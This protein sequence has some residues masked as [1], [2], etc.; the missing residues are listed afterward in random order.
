[1]A[2][3]RKLKSG[4]WQARITHAGRQKSVGSYATKGEAK[5]AAIEAEAK[6]HGGAYLAPAKVTLERFI[7]QWLVHVET[8]RKPTTLAFYQEKA[9]YVLPRLGRMRIDRID[10]VTLDGLYADL[11]ASGGRGGRP[12]SPRTVMHVHRVLRTAFAY[13]V[14]KGML[15][16]N[17]CETADAPRV[18]QGTP[19]VW[20]VPEVQ[21]FLMA[22]HNHRLEAA[23]VLA[24][25][26][27]M[28]R[29]EIAGLTWDAVNLD[30]GEVYVRSTRVM[31][32]GI[33]T[34]S[35]PKTEGSARM[36]A[37]NRSTVQVLREHRTRQRQER[38][39]SLDWADTGYVFTREDGRPV[40]PQYLYTLMQRTAH[41]AGLPPISFHGLRH[42]FAT[43]ALQAKQ[44][45]RLVAELLGHE[46]TRTT[47]STYQHVLPDLARKS[48]EEVAALFDVSEAATTA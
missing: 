17:P 18:G 35:S 41:R 31:A 36:V 5:R 9:G 40:N 15:A 25:K 26:T 24:A 12:L 10:G 28:R 29:G 34:V 43:A 45:V 3:Y 7:E 30:T 2:T 42:S 32:S 27:G 19:K 23:Y 33:P 48:A 1:M 6:V 22:I 21:Q 37:I 16:V 20:G 11:L 39:A 47:Q 46:S 13:A 4:R 8:V 44:D 14:K 38:M